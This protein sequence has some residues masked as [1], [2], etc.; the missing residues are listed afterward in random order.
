VKCAKSPHVVDQVHEADAH[1]GAGQTN[2]AYRL[3]APLRDQICS[4]F[5]P[6]SALNASPTIFKR[7]L[8]HISSKNSLLKRIFEI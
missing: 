6:K 4:Y 7:E 8:L 1:F 2:A 5:E 3:A